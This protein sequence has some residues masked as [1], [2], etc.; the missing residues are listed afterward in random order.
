MFGFVHP[1][2]ELRNGRF[3]RP[4]RA[5][6]EGEFVRGEEERQ[7]RE[8]W[9]GIR[10]RGVSE[11][12]VVQGKFTHAS[13]GGDL[14]E[15][16]QVTASMTDRE[17]RRRRVLVLRRHLSIRIDDETQQLD[18]RK[19]A[20]GEDDPSWDAHLQI[21]RC[22]EARPKDCHDVSGRDFAISDELGTE[23]ETL[24]EHGH[25]DELCRTG[26][27]APERVQLSCCMF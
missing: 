14:A 6:D 17:G 16:T 9:I 27:E 10:T 3:A 5:N 8:D 22:D 24:D 12:D 7:V 1:Q 2:Q 20:L 26:G 15:V 18:H 25:H 13:F 11:C 21:A 19:F 23:P 4:R